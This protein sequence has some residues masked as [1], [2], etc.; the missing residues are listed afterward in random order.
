MEF[1][2]DL[3]QQATTE[4]T[5]G[6]QILDS[7][8]PTVPDD[9]MLQHFVGWEVKAAAGSFD[10]KTAILMDFRCDQT[11]GMHFI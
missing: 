7:R 6:G 2:Y 10:P 9:I 8:P 11:R 5:M 4:Q 3:T 1:R